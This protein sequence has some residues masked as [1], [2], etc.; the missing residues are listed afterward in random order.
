[1]VTWVVSLLLA[2]WLGT[3]AALIWLGWRATG[4]V[5]LRESLIILGGSLA[6]PYVWW[7]FI[8]S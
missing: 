4:E 1:M 7:R 2:A 5:R 6:W 3:A 8:S